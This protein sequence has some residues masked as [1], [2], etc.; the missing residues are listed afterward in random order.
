M[1]SWCKLNLGICY[2]LWI[3]AAY[4]TCGAHCAIYLSVRQAVYPFSNDPLVCK[5]KKSEHETPALK[6]CLLISTIP[7][8]KG[9]FFSLCE[10]HRPQVE[11]QGFEWKIGVYHRQEWI[12]RPVFLGVASWSDDSAVYIK[13]LKDN[14]CFSCG[15]RCVLIAYQY[16]QEFF[17]KA[18]SASN[19]VDSSCSL[20]RRV[21]F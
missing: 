3:N 13:H 6:T 10:Q 16:G 9:C 21:S 17:L 8:S 4:K 2:Q 20:Q 5:Q 11:S 15:L 19:T 7:A 18:S 12:E 14:E 1:L